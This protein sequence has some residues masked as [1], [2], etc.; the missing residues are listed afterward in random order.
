MSF[1]CQ[2]CEEVQPNGCQ[3]KLVATKTRVKQYSN[4][5]GWEIDGTLRLCGDCVVGAENAGE[6][7]REEINTYLEERKRIDER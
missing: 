1:K 4:G 2:G 5:I 3:P 7:A 6:V